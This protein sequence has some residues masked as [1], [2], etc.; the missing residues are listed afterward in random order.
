MQHKTGGWFGGEVPN[1]H[2]GNRLRLAQFIEIDILCSMLAVFVKQNLR[3]NTHSAATA[4]NEHSGM[5][6]RVLCRALFAISLAA[7]VAA[8]AQQGVGISGQALG[9]DV[10]ANF[11]RAHT[12]PPDSVRLIAAILWRGARDWTTNRGAAAEIG[13]VRFDSVR[14]DAERRGALAGGTVTATA[15]AWVEYEPRTNSVVV[16]NQSYSVAHGD[17]T[18]VLMVDR[19][20]HIGG[21]PIVS[22]IRLVCHAT[23]EPEMRSGFTQAVIRSMRYT[24]QQWHTCLSRDPRVAAFLSRPPLR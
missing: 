18:T 10:S 16:L 13:N 9:N 2:V 1:A 7:P 5:L 12:G 8:Q 24:A 19:V 11:I 22:E 17:S 4:F 21:D 6:I 23:S 15:N 3:A 20:D 14:A